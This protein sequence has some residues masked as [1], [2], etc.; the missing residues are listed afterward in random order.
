M[1]VNNHFVSIAQITN[2]LVRSFIVFLLA[3]LW[4]SFY[5]RDM[6]YVFL[7]AFFLTIAINFI[8]EISTKKTRKLR[9]QNRIRATLKPEQ[10]EQYDEIERLIADAME[11]RRIML[12][13]FYA[14]KKLT[15]KKV[16]AGLF[17][18]RRMRGYVVTGLVIFATSFIVRFNIYYIIVATILFSFALLSLFDVSCRHGDSTPRGNGGG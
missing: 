11:M 6:L 4:L 14:D 9:E 1:I 18:R 8:F 15:W 10:R 13:D 5:L 7:L 17:A 2:L 3:Y 16:W 12:K